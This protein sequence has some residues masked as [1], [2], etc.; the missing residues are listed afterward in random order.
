MPPRVSKRMSKFED[1]WFV[2]IKLLYISSPLILPNHIYYIN[3]NYNMSGMPADLE[4]GELQEL[5]E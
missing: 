2:T 4:N 5:L 3:K 1:V